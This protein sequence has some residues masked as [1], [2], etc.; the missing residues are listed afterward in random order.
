MSAEADVRKVIA[1]IDAAWRAK[2]FDGL[3]LCFHEDASIVGPGHVEYARGRQ[4]CAE[5]YIEFANNAAVLAY[6]ESAPTLRVWENV[7]VHT[8]AWDMTYQ[9]DQGARRE[10]GTDQLVFEL[11][12]AGWQLVWRYIH[13]APSE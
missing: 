1:R 2:Q 8:F 12:A 9:R 6:V 7:A 4:K 10:S 11:S 3:E 5:S 13:F